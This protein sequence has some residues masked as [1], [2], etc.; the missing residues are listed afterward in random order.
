M[1]VSQKGPQTLTLTAP[2]AAPLDLTI[3]SD[4]ATAKGT[5]VNKIGTAAS[6]GGANME[7]T[8]VLKG[9]SLSL[10]MAAMTE[11]HLNLSNGLN[12]THKGSASMNCL[13]VRGAAPKDP[14]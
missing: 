2:G 1:E 10:I 4:P 12:G 7:Y 11:G 6:G 9:D 5:L 3:T 13:M 14:R 8:A